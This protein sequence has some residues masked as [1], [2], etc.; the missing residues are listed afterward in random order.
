MPNQQLKHKHAELPHVHRVPIRCWLTCGSSERR[1]SEHLRSGVPLSPAHSPGA[2][3][4]PR[5][6]LG[7]PKVRQLY[8]PVLVHK[9]VLRFDVAVHHARPMYVFERQCQL[10]GVEEDINGFNAEVAKQGIQIAARRKVLNEVDMATQLDSVAKLDNKQV[11]F[12]GG[13]DQPLL[14]GEPC[15]SPVSNPDFLDRII[16][17]LAAL[18]SRP[19]L[20]NRHLAPLAY[21]YTRN[22]FEF[23]KLDWD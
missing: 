12:E 17:R 4:A 8:V 19:P 18:L 1:L 20:A 13:H 16:E 10:R 9:E 22:G 3:R 14:L 21:A 7:K 5:Q 23:F 15:S 6:N 2:W 11:G